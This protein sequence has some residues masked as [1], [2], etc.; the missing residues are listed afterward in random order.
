MPGPFANNVPIDENRPSPNPGPGMT[1][2]EYAQL[3]AR[4]EKYLIT[5]E[6]RRNLRRRVRRL[7][8]T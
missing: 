1:N 3:V 4:G 7:Q 2:G 8:K 6:D 5:E